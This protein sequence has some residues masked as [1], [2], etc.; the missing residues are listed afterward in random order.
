MLVYRNYKK[1]K[2]V[3][4]HAIL[5]EQIEIWK[6]PPSKCLNI[7]KAYCDKYKIDIKIDSTKDKGS[8][9]YLNL[10]GVKWQQKI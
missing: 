4:I 10:K 7:I 5:Q 1:L 2:G 3:D 8:V 6:I 9:F